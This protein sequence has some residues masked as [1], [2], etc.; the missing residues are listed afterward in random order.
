MGRPIL[1][2]ALA[3]LAGGALAGCATPPCDAH[4]E[5]GWGRSQGFEQAMHEY[6]NT[7]K[8]PPAE[9][10][11]P[12]CDG[13][14]NVDPKTTDAEIL[15]MARRCGTLAG[16]ADLRRKVLARELPC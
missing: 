13:L 4:C 8:L 15:A 11:V 2:L 16:H 6:Y 12:I 9:E 14:E 7:G 3:T 1:L 5:Y 10:D